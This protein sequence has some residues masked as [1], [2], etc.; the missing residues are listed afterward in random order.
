MS[1][2]TVAAD[3]PRCDFVLSF[4]YAGDASSEVT[5]VFQQAEARARGLRWVQL[6]PHLSVTGAGA[7]EWV[8]IRPK[9][10]AAVLFAMLH[11]LVWE[12]DWRVACDV[13]FLERM[14]SSPYLVG[15]GGS[16]LRDPATAKPV[17]WD[18][19]KGRPLPFDSYGLTP[20]LDGEFI[21]AGIEIGPDGARRTVSERVKTAFAHLRDHVRSYTPEWAAA[22]SD[23]PAATIRRLACEYVA[24]ATVGAT[25]V[26]DGVQYPH[27]PVAVLLGETV[28]DGCGGYESCWA[29]TVLAALVGALEVPGGMFGVG[30]GLRHELPCRERLEA[31]PAEYRAL[32]AWKDFA[33]ISRETAM[34][35]GRR[36]EEFPF[37]LL[38]GRSAQRHVEGHLGV[39]LNR[40]AAQRLGIGD[41]DLIEIELPTGGKTEGR[42]VLR[43]GVHPD[44][45]VLLPGRVATMDL[46]LTE[47]T[48]GGADLVPV[49]IRPAAAMEVAGSDGSEAR[50]WTSPW[51]ARLRD[52]RERCAIDE[53][54]MRGL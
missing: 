37:W 35:F 12:Q 39:M 29:R 43:E 34:R 25:T 11:V 14:T 6:E 22:I 44:V 1:F 17:V 21:A 49:A 8:P 31:E 19:G 5:G 16:F 50:S 15:P 33:R 54:Y 3:L 13:P 2:L 53:A 30:Q 18:E 9:T 51:L 38:T 4:G 26:I 48:G 32:P 46:A 24:H 7:A 28:T 47:A 45:A 10:D 40:G 41:G 36:P 52:P 23:V 42:A 20:A 27:R